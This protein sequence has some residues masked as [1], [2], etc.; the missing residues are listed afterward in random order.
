MSTILDFSP[1]ATTKDTFHVDAPVFH[2]D[3]IEQPDEG[4]TV[5]T[6]NVSSESFYTES[7]V[8]HLIRLNRLRRLRLW[9]GVAVILSLCALIVCLALHIPYEPAAALLSSLMGIF[10]VFAMK[11]HDGQR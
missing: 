7:L 10:V 6:L 3:E 5:S 9:F 8:L 4:E 2:S 1:R 11:V